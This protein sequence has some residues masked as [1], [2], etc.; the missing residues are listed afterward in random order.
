M[1]TR[2]I[3][4]VGHVA[5]QVTD[6]ESAVEHAT[7]IM[8][9]RVSERTADQADLTH[10]SP[11]HSLQYVRGDHEGVHHVGLVAT[12]AEALAEIRDR[13]RV[14]EIPLLSESALD[15][16][17]ADGLAFVAPGGF[18]VE[19]YIG[20]PRDQPRY[21]P[22]GVRPR[23][24][25]HVNFGA[26]D[27]EIL[28]DLFLNVLDFRVSDHFRG[29]AFTRCNSDHHGIGV[30]RGRDVL[31]HYAYEAESIADL[32]RLGDVLEDA[33]SEL[34]TGPVRHGMGEN[35]AVYIEAPGNNV[36]EYY[37]DML[38]IHD[39]TSYTPGVW[40]EA[41]YKWYTRWSPEVPG[42][43]SRV[44]LLGAAPVRGLTA[45]SAAAVTSGPDSP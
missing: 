25:G 24:F 1:G 7:T 18:V 39:E 28:L 29:G 9:L 30:L 6:L 4:A 37:T 23:R 40:D 5:I 38:R 42:P 31:A 12:D 10:G 43:D 35:I 15:P 22:T 20:M 8:G 26:S 14:R 3:A 11:H 16:C 34:L 2:V 33:G 21:Q 41:G 17:L 32:G 36:V 19:V 13:L 45:P 27:P 44:R